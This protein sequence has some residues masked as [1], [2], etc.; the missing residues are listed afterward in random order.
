MAKNDDYS[1]I[2]SVPKW[3][4]T[5]AD[6]LKIVKDLTSKG[7]YVV[8]EVKGATPG[9]QHWVAIDRVN[10]DSMV[11]MDPGYGKTRLWDNFYKVDKTSTFAYFKVA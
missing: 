7:Y 4:K 5:K 8:A 11:I 2:Y 3:G 6:K 10:N 1:K 9:N